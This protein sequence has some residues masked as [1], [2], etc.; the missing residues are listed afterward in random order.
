MKKTKQKHTRQDKT[1]QNKVG[2][3]G[4]HVR[5]VTMAATPLQALVPLQRD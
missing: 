4:G 1:K 2:G 5:P 3:W